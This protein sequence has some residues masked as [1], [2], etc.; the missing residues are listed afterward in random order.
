MRV[1]GLKHALHTGALV[2][3]KEVPTPI[4]EGSKFSYTPQNMRDQGDIFMDK[5]TK[6]PYSLGKKGFKPFKEYTK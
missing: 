3:H 6:P 5:W 4:K 1:N 2:L